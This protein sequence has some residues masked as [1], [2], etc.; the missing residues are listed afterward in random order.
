MNHNKDADRP[1]GNVT[2]LA[3]HALEVTPDRRGWLNRRQAD[4][5]VRGATAAAAGQP[6]AIIVRGTLHGCD[7]T[8]VMVLASILSQATNITVYG[9]GRGIPRLA[10]HLRSAIAQERAWAAGRRQ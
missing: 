2:V 6:A 3:A 5:A 8:A 9:N 10:A 4:R 1:D 7:H